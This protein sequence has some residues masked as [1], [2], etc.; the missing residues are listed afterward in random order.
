MADTATPSL[1]DYLDELTKHLAGQLSA[2]LLA[3]EVEAVHQSRVATR[4]LTAALRL[5]DPL[6]TGGRRKRLE[7][8]L[9]KMRRRLG[10]LRDLDVMMDHLAELRV[11]RK[12]SDAI[13]WLQ[14]QMSTDR[15]SAQREA[16]QDIPLY[17]TLGQL[18]EWRLIRVQLQESN[19][20]L[21]ELIAQSLNQQMD[22]FACAAGRLAPAGSQ[23]SAERPDAHAVRIAGKALRYTLEMADAS[24]HA[25]SPDIFKLF[26]N[27]QDALGTWHDFVVLTEQIMLRSANAMVAHHDIALQTQLLHLAT[28]TL[29]T[30]QKQLN[31]FNRLWGDNGQAVTTAIRAQF[32]LCR[33][34][35]DS[36][37]DPPG[38]QRANQSQT[39]PDPSPTDQS[40]DSES[41]APAAPS[42]A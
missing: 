5:I 22:E 38:D 14:G 1:L 33:E 32:P 27:M 3:G 24:G 4:R 30:A 16:T 6:I 20:A 8:A 17:K 35:S 40:G 41:P 26:K 11:D 2:A 13:D 34:A 12:E 29:A 19:D 36:A 15:E 25:L 9:K 37:I 21:P 7:K 31:K 42:D 28:A 18:E 39:D 10:N 23:Q